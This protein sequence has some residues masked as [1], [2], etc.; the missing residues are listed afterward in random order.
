[1]V[2]IAYFD[3]LYYVYV[4]HHWEQTPAD[5][6]YTLLTETQRGHKQLIWIQTKIGL[7]W[8]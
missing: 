5:H 8:S 3:S 2:D 1:M 7:Q 6:Q 4:Y